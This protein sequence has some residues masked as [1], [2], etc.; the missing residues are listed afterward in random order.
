M[1]ADPLAEANLALDRGDLDA[2]VRGYQRALRIVP[3]S[4]MGHLKLAEVYR[5]K[6]AGRDRALLALAEREFGEALRV[7][8]PAEAAHLQ[9]I[10]LGLA[11]GR[12][13]QLRAAYAVG[14]AQ[15]A[16]PFARDCLAEIDAARTPAPVADASLTG[17]RVGLAVLTCLL[18]LGGW[19]AWAFW[20]VA[21]RTVGHAVGADAKEQAPAF[22]LRD[23]EGRSVMLADFRGTSVVVLDFWAT[24]CGP[25]RA[26]MPAVENFRRAH[27]GRGVEV[28]SVN[29]REDPATVKDF[30][31]R[32][33]REMH[34]LLDT[35]GAVAGAYNVTGIPTLVIIDKDGGLRD[36]VVGYRA[37]LEEYLESVVKGLL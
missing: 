5:R 23:L 11:L 6:A 32:E 36:R 9:L 35:L 8:P 15:A 10:A 31:A 14:G 24:W 4:F 16:I 21:V 22:S 17:S 18:V 28:L 19:A 30:L 33:H 20:P 12:R 3:D 13:E 29:L 34:V 7:V 25:C 26:S 2:A 27:L 37:D 1:H